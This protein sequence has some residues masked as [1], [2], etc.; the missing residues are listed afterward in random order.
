M[1]NVVHLSIT[2][3]CIACGLTVWMVPKI[4][5]KINEI[6]LQL[7]VDVAEFQ[8]LEKNIWLGRFLW[9]YS[10]FIGR[11]IVKNIFSLVLFPRLEVLNVKLN[12]NVTVMHII[13]VHQD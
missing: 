11:Y 1:V 8:E 9:I 12:R 7:M 3:A 10:N 5:Y 6:Q 4:I 13:L 2:L